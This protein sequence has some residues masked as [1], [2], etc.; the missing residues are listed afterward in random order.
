MTKIIPLRLA[1]SN[2]FVLCG[3]RPIL[4]D[5]GGPRDLPALTRQLN[6]HDIHIA[7]LAL[8]LLTHVHFDHAGSA[9]A[10]QR[11]GCPLAV[12][13]LEGEYLARGHSAPII[14]V[15]ALGRLLMPFMGAG[16]APA[17]A[18]MLIEER[19][20][21]ADYGVQAEVMCTPGHTPGSLSVMTSD[22]QAL[23]GD[24]CGGGWPV[25]Q[26]QPSRPRYHYW[27]SS[28]E[29]V[30]TSLERVCA[31]QPSQIYVGHGGP[32]DGREAREFFL[33]T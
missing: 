30:Q 33:A 23:V 31:F 26:F 1:T 25:G 29:E 4:I 27:A 12:H 32:L 8:L 10:I 15:H 24:L 5:C 17:T 11:V 21:L 9:A 3:A 7:D 22:G 28:L 14:P 2:A 19:L 20:D 16:F 18:D 13:R 6:R